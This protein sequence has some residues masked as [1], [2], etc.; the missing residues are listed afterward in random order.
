MKTEQM[1]E[2]NYPGS[3]YDESSSE[4]CGHNNP[5]KAIV[6]K[7]ACSFRFFDRVTQ[8]AT[9]EDGTVKEDIQHKNKSSTYY[10]EATV[11]NIE[12]VK[13]LTGDYNILIS[14]MEANQWDFVVRTRR[15]NFQ[16]FEKEDRLI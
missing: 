4:V 8:N 13:K 1:I 16:L 5:K 10:P 15:G 9:L 14:N 11:L 2:F 7:G 3:F 12:D 6:P